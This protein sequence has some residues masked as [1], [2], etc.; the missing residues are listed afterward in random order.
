MAIYN[1]GPKVTVDAGP[2]SKPRVTALA[3]GTFLVT[4]ND[5]GVY[6]KIFNADGSLK[7][8]TEIFFGVQNALITA[9]NDGNFLV[10]GISPTTGKSSASI[11]SPTSGTKLSSFIADVGTK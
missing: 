9:L 6:G 10:I 2:D 1:W 4:Y 11:W 5:G 7:T 3:D 8:G